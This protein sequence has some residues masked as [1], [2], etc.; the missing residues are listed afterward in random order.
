MTRGHLT[1]RRP[2]RVI[3]SWIVGV[4][5]L[6]V[7]GLAG[8]ASGLLLA[9]ERVSALETAGTLS[10]ESPGTLALGAVLLLAG[11]LVLCAAMWPGRPV[12]SSIESAGLGSDS[13][14]DDL[15]CAVTTRG[16]GRLAEGEAQRTDG[17]TAV[18]A[19]ATGRRLTVEAQSVAAELPET[20]QE[21]QDR[22][23]QR[24]QGLQLRRTPRV[25]VRV[26]R[27]GVS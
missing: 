13:P 9:G 6:I 22:I 19:R 26:R 20:R 11:L 7:A 1:R 15:Q 5:V 21:I 2:Q 10:W 12:V 8:W 23:S 24:L 17:V 3:A 14:I 25:V 18:R 4:A 16:L 27:G